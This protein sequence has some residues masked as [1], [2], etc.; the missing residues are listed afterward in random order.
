MTH[1]DHELDDATL[2]AYVDGQ[3]EPSRAAEVADRLLRQPRAAQRVLAW[4]EQREALQA[5]HRDWLDEPVP[6]RLSAAMS[7]WSIASSCIPPSLTGDS[8]R[9]ILRFDGSATA[10][11]PAGA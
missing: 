10:I 9:I 1:D 3:L 4:R 5:L 6:S 2:H 8:P 7:F 11:R